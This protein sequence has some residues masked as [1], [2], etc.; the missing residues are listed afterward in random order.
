MVYC[1]TREFFIYMET[2]PFPVRGCKFWTMFG[3]HGHWTRRVLW[4]VTPT[5]TRAYVYNT[6]LLGTVTL[7]TIVERLAVELSLP[8]FTTYV[9]RGWDSNIQP[10]SWSLSIRLFA[11]KKKCVHN[12]C[13]YTK[14][15]YQIVKLHLPTLLYPIPDEKKITERIPNRNKTKSLRHIVLKLRVLPK[16]NFNKGKAGFLGLSTIVS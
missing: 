11:H 13:T 14:F 6:H 15:D 5:V 1:P 2:S 7:T 9:C 8:V 12:F 4:C 16:N 3:T 10:S